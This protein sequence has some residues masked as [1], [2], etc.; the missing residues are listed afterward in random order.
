MNSVVINSF[1]EKWRSVTRRTL[2]IPGGVV[3]VVTGDDKQV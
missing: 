2:V 1:L 3:S